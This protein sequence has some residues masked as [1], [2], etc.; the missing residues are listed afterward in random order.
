[1]ANEELKLFFQEAVKQG[2]KEETIRKHIQELLEEAICK[3]CPVPSELTSSEFGHI[4]GMIKDLGD[5]DVGKGVEVIRD[6]HRW[7]SEFRTLKNK[8]F[9]AFLIAVVTVI[10]SGVMALVWTALKD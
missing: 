9:N 3:I 5:G 6:N 1:M 4:L 10:T 8:I 2:L 7:T